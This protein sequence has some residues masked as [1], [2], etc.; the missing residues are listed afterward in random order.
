MQPLMFLVAF[1]AIAGYYQVSL[2]RELPPVV[3]TVSAQETA[4][5]MVVYFNKVA[6]Y[7]ATKTAGYTEPSAGNTVPDAAL[8]LPGWYIRNPL[9][10]NRVVNGVVTVYAT[11][12]PRAGDI[13]AALVKVSGAVSGT[14]VTSAATGTILNPVFGNTGVAFPA[15]LPDGV[16]II[17][18]RV[19]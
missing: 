16:P 14:G 5:N 3:A 7:V 10:T 11:E 1:L 12:V 15:S 8:G 18:S 13:T 4:L 19:Q 6:A 9:W 17:Q 2:Q